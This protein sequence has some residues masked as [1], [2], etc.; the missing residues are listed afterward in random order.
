MLTQ[1]MVSEFRCSS[2]ASFLS[3][4]CGLF[5]CAVYDGA[6][7]ERNA[8]VAPVAE[9]Q[10]D[11]ASDAQS[12]SGRC[13]RA[14]CDAGASVLRKMARD[15]APV[16]NANRRLAERDAEADLKPRRD[17]GDSAGPLDSGAVQL[18]S[19]SDARVADARDAETG[20]CTTCDSAAPVDPVLD[21]AG[22]RG[23]VT[24]LGSVT[25]PAPSTGGACNYGATSL[26]Y[27]AAINV[28][29]QAG[30][31]RGHW[32]AGRI[33]GQCAAV[34]VKTEEGWKETFVRV[35]DKCS[36]PHCGIA[37]S[38]AAAKAVM[39]ARTGR[40]DGSWRFVSCTGHPETSDGPPTIHVKEGS[41]TAWALVQLR[42]ATQAVSSIT[43]QS[44]DGKSSGAFAY[45][46]EAENYFSVPEAVR[47]SDKV[48][49]TVHYRDTTT[50]ALVV[51]AKQLTSPDS[52]IAL[53]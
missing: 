28:D 45:A 12:T 42:N 9:R 13:S 52:V 43:W 53:P 16:D 33:C 26:F 29:V 30:D 41:S 20:L 4:L 17:K 18:D 19:G 39:G 6:T 40:Y 34:R 14:L 24:S 51:S 5:S 21:E 22:G 11:G 25:S 31:A 27:F 35:V 47:G 48:R 7:L 2:R 50:A 49:L 37:L 36:D 38:G 10:L 32:Q 15:A 1:T 8:K 3:A 44:S 23:N 46:S